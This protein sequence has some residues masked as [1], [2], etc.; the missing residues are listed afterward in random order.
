VDSL[1]RPKAIAV[2]ISRIGQLPEKITLGEVAPFLGLTRIDDNFF[3][4]VTGRANAC[5]YTFEIGYGDAYYLVCTVP[6]DR[7][8]GASS[9]D[10]LEVQ[11][12]NI[13]EK[14]DGGPRYLDVGPGWRP[15][16]N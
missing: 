14:H 8:T 10:S 15:K 2:A 7:L 13:R 5:V 16:R 12:V 4:E 1:T 3:Q 9:M 6:L 11:Y